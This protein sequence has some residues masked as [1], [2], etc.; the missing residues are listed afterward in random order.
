MKRETVQIAFLIALIVG[1][2]YL[3]FRMLAPFL[4]PIAWAITLVILFQPVHRRVV[5]WARNANVAALLSCLLVLAVVIVPAVVIVMG[6]IGE[7]IAAYRLIEERFASGAWAFRFELGRSRILERSASWLAHYAD[8]GELNLHALIL[9]NLQRL[10]GYLATRSAEVVKQ[11]SAFVFNLGV[12]IF[13]MYFLFRDGA[14]LMTRLK[15]A[16]PLPE[17]EA[18]EV[19]GRM[20]E[21]IH[22]TLYGGLA[23]AVSQG[24]LGGIAFWIVGLPSP[25]TWGAVMFFF[26]FLPV[27]GAAI[28]WVPAAIVLMAQGSVGKGLF[29]LLWGA[30]VISTVDNVLRPWVI[31]GRTRVPTVL[32][33]FSV[34][35]GVK[36]FGFI[37]VVMGPVV[38]SVALALAEI[39]RRKLAPVRAPEAPV[40]AA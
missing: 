10:S 23:V 38:L 7:L 35:G 9:N 36:L 28:I 33:F 39:F 32:I 15:R 31:G 17:A 21:T 19:L 37:G 30:L 27:V 18:D 13:T 2:G 6:L 29:L 20:Q 1:V 25:L 5:R 16:I 40:D 14:T 11:F 26:S 8:L 22:A 4:S 24:A 3:F 34:L 12:A